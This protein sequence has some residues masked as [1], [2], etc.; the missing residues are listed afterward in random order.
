[1]PS[2]FSAWQ[3]LIAIGA[4]ATALTA[5]GIA[6]RRGWV[7]LSSFVRRVDASSRIINAEM[8]GNGGGTLLDKVN[9][10]P[11]IESQVTD[12]RDRM[13]KVEAKL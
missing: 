6:I 12:L 3:T 10:I 8:V 4:G 7:A 1:M 2:D 5:I 9:R 13:E 11:A